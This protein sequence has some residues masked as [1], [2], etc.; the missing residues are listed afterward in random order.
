MRSFTIGVSVISFSMTVGL[1]LFFV[2]TPSAAVLHQVNQTSPAE[3]TC[4]WLD[5]A[6]S[7][8]KK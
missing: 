4:I 3:L 5:T 7:C 1:G 8:D 2:A 6:M